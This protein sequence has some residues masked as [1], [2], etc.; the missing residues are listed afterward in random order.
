M[1]SSVIVFAFYFIFTPNWEYHLS[2][3]IVYALRD[4]HIQ[5]KHQFAMPPPSG[6]WYAE[7]T[8]ADTTHANKGHSMRPSFPPSPGKSCETWPAFRSMSHL[9][10]ATQYQHNWW[11]CVHTHTYTLVRIHARSRSF[12]LIYSLCLFLK[13]SL[14]LPANN[15]Y[16]LTFALY[17]TGRGVGSNCAAVTT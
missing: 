2:T 7:T 17:G 6:N 16:T 5:L 13:I 9:F 8:L 15:R 10:I 14:P 4:D 11:R 3:S 12:S 1:M